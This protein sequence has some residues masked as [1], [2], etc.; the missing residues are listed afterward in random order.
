MIIVDDGI[1][2]GATVI[3]AARQ[4]RKENPDEI[5]IAVPVISDSS[6]NQIKNEVDRVVYLYRPKLFFSVSQFYRDFNQVNDEEVKEILR[7]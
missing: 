5:I 2:T 3:A 1:A 6:F 4:V 7:K